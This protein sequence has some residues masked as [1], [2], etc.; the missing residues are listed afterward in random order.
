MGYANKIQEKR[1]CPMGQ[2]DERWNVLTY[3]G[4]CMED[5]KGDKLPIP[6][7]NKVVLT[8]VDT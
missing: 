7:E 2:D 3:L 8:Q 1:V 4:E 6:E 5:G